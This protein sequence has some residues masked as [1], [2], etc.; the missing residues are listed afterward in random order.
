MGCT[1]L[2]LPALFFILGLVGPLAG[3]RANSRRAETPEILGLSGVA[4]GTVIV[5][6]MALHPGVIMGDR[7]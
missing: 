2:E 4:L 7:T 5:L 3:N 1:L 6:T